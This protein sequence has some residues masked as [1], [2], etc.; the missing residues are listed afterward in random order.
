MAVLTVSSLT[1]VDTKLLFP[2][3]L[4]SGGAPASHALE[5]SS[6]LGGLKMRVFEQYSTKTLSIHFLI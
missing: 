5:A 4:V 1:G 2:V 3:I 6:H